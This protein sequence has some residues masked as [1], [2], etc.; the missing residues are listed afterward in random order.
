VLAEDV[1]AVVAG[2]R[3]GLDKIN[4]TERAA[5]AYLC[6]LPDGWEVIVATW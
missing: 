3:F 6:A 5:L 1:R 2:L 4:I